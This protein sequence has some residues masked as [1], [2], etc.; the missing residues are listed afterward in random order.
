MGGADP[1][2]N[3]RDRRAPHTY[4]HLGF[5]RVSASVVSEIADAKPDRRR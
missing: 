4:A 1:T 5:K 2:S 3:A